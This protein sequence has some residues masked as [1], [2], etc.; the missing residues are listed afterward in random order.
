MLLLLTHHLL[1]LLPPPPGGLLAMT[2][3][4]FRQMCRQ[5]VL[6]PP[7]GTSWQQQQQQLSEQRVTE[8]EAFLEQHVV[9][10][11]GRL[12][13]PAWDTPRDIPE[14]YQCQECGARRS[15]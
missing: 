3:D 12:V 4:L 11:H 1:L 10:S 13:V 8:L 7:A 6:L 14:M 9:R 15:S 2:P 5:G